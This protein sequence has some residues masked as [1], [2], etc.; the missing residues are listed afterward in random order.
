MGERAVDMLANDQFQQS[1]EKVC[2]VPDRYREFN[3]DAND[4]DRRFAIKGSL[5]AALLDLGLPHARKGG[6]LCFDNYDLMNISLDLRLLGV[7]WRFMRLWPRSLSSARRRGNV[8]Y[9]FTLRVAC[10]HPGHLGPC[11]YKLNPKFD[12]SIEIE[13]IS[14]QALQFQGNLVSEAYDFGNSIDPIIAEACRLQFHV[15]PNAASYDMEFLNDSGLA[16][17]QSAAIWLIQVGARHGIVARPAMGLFVSVPYSV[18]HVWLEIST[19]EGWKQADPFFL[20][21]LA[22]WGLIQLSDWPLSCSP[23]FAIFRIAPDVLLDEPLI[24]HR[25]NRAHWGA[26]AT[27]VVPGVADAATGSAE[28]D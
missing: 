5:L 12:D 13:E 6:E 18:Q 26:V 21:S 19:R 8:P 15:L 22:R 14:P 28:N 2:R 3:I 11:D 25:G 7:Q 20:N 10:P 23:Q 17:C 9:Q 16:T 24:L 1:L 4:A 27:A